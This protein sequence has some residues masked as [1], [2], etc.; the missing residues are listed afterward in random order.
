[1]ASGAAAW[2]A[3]TRVPDDSIFDAGDAVVWDNL[4]R[5]SRQSASVETAE[6]DRPAPPVPARVQPPVRLRATAGPPWS[7]VIDGLPGAQAGLVVGTGDVVGPYTVVHIGV[8][9]V[10][11]RDRD[12]TWT[13]AFSRP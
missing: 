7:A 2:P 10:M 12:T 11:I 5:L 9:R 8:D 6:S 4:F 1:M 3:P 13:F